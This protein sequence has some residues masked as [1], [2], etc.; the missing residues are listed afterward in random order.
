M[1]VHT[2]TELKPRTTALRLVSTKDLSRSDWLDV[3]KKGIGSSDASAAVGLNP[4]QSRLEL[5]MVKTGR[6]AALPKPDSD[7]PTSPVYW[8]HILEPIVAEQY[9]KQTGRKVRRVN[10]VLQ[11]PDPDK[12][13]MLANLDYSV[14]ASE[15]VQILECKTT[16]EFG[17]WLWKEGVPDYVQCQV[18]HQLAVT[19][20]QAADVCV[21]LCGQKL[22]IYR[23]ERNE[24][25]ITDLIEL[26][27]EFWR[28]VETDTPPPADGSE[29][30][31]RALRALY[32]KDNGVCLDLT[33]DED[34]S[35]CFDQLR[36]VREQ[37]EALAA[38]EARLKQTIQGCMGEATTAVFRNGW[39]S[40][41]RSKDSLSLNTKALLKDQPDLLTQYPLTKTGSR[42][43]LIH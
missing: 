37:A 18:Q 32:P 36:T 42:R 2:K 8:G 11:H 15:D 3:R 12:H 20:K 38:N 27:R 10:A 41:K 21:L 22:E 39:V 5:W 4:Y 23:V 31:D 33:E 1:T 9:S 29:S 7:D 40:W 6:D 30:A 35:D 28:Y 34:L 16:G 25:L 19:G 26:E 43:F 13:W 24:A 14:V 17:A